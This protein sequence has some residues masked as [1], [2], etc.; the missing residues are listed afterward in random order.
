MKEKLSELEKDLKEKIE[1][2]EIEKEESKS[3]SE[4]LG[5]V[6]PRSQNVSVECD[7]SSSLKKIFKWKLKEMELE[8]KI[9]SQRLKLTSDLFEV[10]KKEAFV[11]KTCNSKRFCR[12][13]HFKHNFKKSCIQETTD[14]CKEIQ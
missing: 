10:K 8:E 12:I 3:L 7:P 11:D 14:R 9:N 5:I 6:D 2:K 4:E 13:N 1:A